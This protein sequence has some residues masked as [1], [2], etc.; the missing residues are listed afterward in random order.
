MYMNM[1]SKRNIKA[2][3]WPKREAEAKAM[4]NPKM[5]TTSNTNPNKS[6]MKEERENLKLK[7]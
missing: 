5:K 1:E 3:R 4:E 7:K 6:N 2:E